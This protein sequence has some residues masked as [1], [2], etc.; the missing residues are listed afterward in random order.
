MGQT[1]RQ[2]FNMVCAGGREHKD[3][4]R[5]YHSDSEWLC[6]VKERGVKNILSRTNNDDG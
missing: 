2:E 6:V 5:W 4:G 3:E 1:R